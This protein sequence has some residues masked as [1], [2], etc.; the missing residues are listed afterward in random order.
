MIDFPNQIPTDAIMLVIDKIRGR[1]DVNNREFAQ[2]LWN[3]VGYAASQALPED[4]TI[5]EGR[6]IGL[7]DFASLLEQAMEQ[8]QY[9]ANPV[10]IGIIPWALILKTALKVLIS[11]FL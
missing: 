9:H 5:F 4:K 7:E 8:S 2:A 1:K 11:A 3:V 6:E 10:T